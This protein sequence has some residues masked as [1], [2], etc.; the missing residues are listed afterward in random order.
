MVR[1]LSGS[2]QS[3]RNARGDGDEACPDQANHDRQ[4][5]INLC[6]ER[7][8]KKIGEPRNHEHKD[9]CQEHGRTDGESDEIE[10]SRRLHEHGE[11]H[12]EEGDGG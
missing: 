8:R 5:G 4:R 12:D 6:L 11:R 2:A 10:G 7:Q 3:I 9:E 1:Q